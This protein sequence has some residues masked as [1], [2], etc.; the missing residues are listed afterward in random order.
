[1]SR[2]GV[3]LLEIPGW[4]CCGNSAGHA[5]NRL[6]ATALPT[7]ELAKVRN[8]MQL[9]AVAVPCAACY[10]RFRFAAH[11]LETSPA[12]AGDVAEVVGRPY[13]GGVQVLNLIDVYHQRIGLET[14]RERVV[15][16]F[17]DLP[18]AAYY[19]CL[20]TRPPKSTL[21]DDPEYPMHMDQVLE[22]IGCRAV[23]WDAKTDCCGAGLAL[24]ERDIADR[25]ITRIIANARDRGA[26][27]IVCAC[28]LCQLNLDSRQIEI[29]RTETDWVDLP[30][31]Y[32]SQL[33]GRALG[34]ADDELGAGKALIDV[35]GVLAA[36]GD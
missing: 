31:L 18:V 14:L 6:L 26:E 7:G 33:V 17:D 8:D 21:A 9:D 25:L 29:R 5:T 32:L 15:A 12:V 34:M 3:D 22:A 10:N 35:R 23:A 24:A 4:V 11:E 16:P 36:S 13:G 30:I 2:L 19:G 27:A 1:M 20:L 28:P